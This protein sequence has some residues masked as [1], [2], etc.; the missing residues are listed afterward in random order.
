MPKL[1]GT[2]VVLNYTETRRFDWTD[3]KTNTVRPLQNIVGLMAHGDGQITEQQISFPRDAGWHPPALAAKA[4]YLFPVLISV[5]KKGR[6]TYTMRT[7]VPPCRHRK[8]TDRSTLPGITPGAGASS[9]TKGCPMTNVPTQLDLQDLLHPQDHP[10]FIGPRLPTSHPAY[11]AWFVR[12]NLPP[13]DYI[14]PERFNR[15]LC[16]TIKGPLP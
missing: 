8:S 16:I 10:D 9:L 13:P 7:D 4:D 14:D 5:S 11:L 1:T 12:Q 3:P 15:T 6:I 2:W